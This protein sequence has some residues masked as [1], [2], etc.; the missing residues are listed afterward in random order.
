MAD[1]ASV[2][3]SDDLYYWDQ[4]VHFSAWHVLGAFPGDGGCRFAV[5]AP[6]AQYVSVVGDFNGWD[7]SSHPLERRG[8]GIWE[9]WVEGAHDGQRYKY[10][11]GAPGGFSADKTDPYALRMEPPNEQGDKTLGL[12]ALVT[13]RTPYTWNDGDWMNARQGPSG[14]NRPLSIY[15]VHLGSWQRP[16]DGSLPNYR[17]LAEPL[18]NHALEYGFTHVELMPV[19]EHPYYGSWG[20]QVVGYYAPTFRYGSPDDLR[21]LIDYLHQRGLGVILDWVPAHFATDPHALSQFD[22]SPLYEDADPKMANHPDW[23]TFVFDWGRPGVRNFLVSNALYWFE[24]FHIDGLRF[25]AVASMLYRDYSRGDAWTPNRHGGREHLEAISFLQTVNEEVYKRFPQALM[26][27]EE[28]TSWP[29]VTKPTYDDGLGF[30]YKWN[31]G[32]MHDTLAFLDEEPVNRK[33]HYDSLTFPL[34]YAWSEHY[35]LPLSHDE[36]VHGKGSLWGKMPGDDWQKAA[37]LR[38]LFGHMIGHPGKKLLFMGME[39]GQ[40]SEW[41]EAK[42]LDWEALQDPTHAGIAQWTQDI[43][44]LYRDH[45]ALWNESPSGFEWFEA[46]D[47]DRSIAGYRRRGPDESG[48]MRELIFAFNFTPVAREN[49]RIGVEA[50]QYRQVLT[51]DDLH[52]G[53]SGV[54]AYGEIDLHPVGY[55]GRS[56]SL[57]TTL[58][59]LGVL[60]LEREV[61]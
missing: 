9:G 35:A 46:G 47:A 41:A 18:A 52:Y 38:L 15:E 17:D 4:G 42:Q 2:L 16:W 3:S 57:V 20:Y 59:P 33:W 55:H 19:M 30:L 31:M 48:Q 5:W 21:F 13:N 8:A 32:W 40:R 53:G 54:G 7:R 34:V 56:H 29:G 11:I 14:M 25:D 58:P 36:V 24:E 12:S 49:Y 60:I 44:S 45:P 51:S 61:G 10:H 26:I 1:H 37:N 39:W 28:S 22:G 27:A 23:G 43:F 50:G 6:N